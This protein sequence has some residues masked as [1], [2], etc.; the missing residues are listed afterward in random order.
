MDEL[1][2]I[3][4]E[5][6][7]FDERLY[8]LDVTGV[9]Q[10]EVPKIIDP[11]KDLNDLEARELVVCYEPNRKQIIQLAFIIW[12]VA[13][14]ERNSLQ[15]KTSKFEAAELRCT[16]TRKA[17]GRLLL[18]LFGGNQEKAKDFCVTLYREHKKDIDKYISGWEIIPRPSS[19]WIDKDSKNIFLCQNLGRVVVGLSPENYV[20]V[21]NPKE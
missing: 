5:L 2:K 19:I 14:H 13:T 7:K 21:Y 9:Q 10:Y 8:T 15:T 17:L 16:D 18:P 20:F 1:K 12:Q 3:V 6:V 11:N 4:E